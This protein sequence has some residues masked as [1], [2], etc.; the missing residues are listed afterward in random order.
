MW[1]DRDEGVFDG[2]SSHLVFAIAYKIP[3]QPLYHVDFYKLIQMPS[4]E[5]ELFEYKLDAI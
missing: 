3:R 1:I 2:D 4:G 5:Y